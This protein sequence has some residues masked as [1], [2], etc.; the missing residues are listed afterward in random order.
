MAMFGKR[1]SGKAGTDSSGRYDVTH[2][3]SSPAQKRDAAESL[4]RARAAMMGGSTSPA[5]RPPIPGKPS[6]VKISSDGPAPQPPSDTRAARKANSPK[7]KEK[8]LKKINKKP[9]TP[10]DTP[11]SKTGFKQSEAASDYDSARYAEQRLA[12]GDYPNLIHRT[13]KEQKEFDQDTV[14]AYVATGKSTWSDEGRDWVDKKGSGAK[15][16]RDE[17]YG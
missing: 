4:A 9:L 13:G 12:K 1:V 3:G 8:A 7:A 17:E 10:E 5:A 2:P 16:K 6:V 14:G 15:K 11:W